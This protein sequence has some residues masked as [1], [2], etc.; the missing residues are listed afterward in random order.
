MLTADGT[1]D[2]QYARALAAVDFN[3]LRYA[4]AANEITGQAH[5]V[6]KV[7]YFLYIALIALLERMFGGGWVQAIVAVNVVAQTAVAAI[8]L[9]LVRANAG[10]GCHWCRPQRSA[11]LRSITCNGPR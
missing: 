3:P 7:S 11:S 8:V 1:R 10:G 4:S 2:N 6:P 5:P 9:S